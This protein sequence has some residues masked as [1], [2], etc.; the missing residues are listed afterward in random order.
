[1]EYVPGKTVDQLIG[2]HGPM[3]VS[4]A[5]NIVLQ[6]VRAIRYYKEFDI[7]HRDIKPSNII[8]TKQNIAKLGDFG[9]VKSKLD[10]E[11]GYEGMVLGTPDYISPEQAMGDDNLDWR[12]DIYSLG[13]TFYHMVTG[14]PP[15]EGSGSTVMVK[16]VKEQPASPKKYNPRL[17]DDVCAI[18]EKMMS[19]RPVDR[20]AS[21]ELLFEDLEILR[22]GRSTR[23]PRLEVGKS[24]IF[25]AFKIEQARLA[26]ITEEKRTLEDDAKKLQLQLDIQTKF[27]FILG[28]ISCLLLVLFIFSIL[29]II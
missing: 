10:K 1:M 2:E 5:V 20:Y 11:L 17:P 27:I 13:A 21:L 22:A 12:S 15:F 16:H 19:K 24:S 29:G 25:R 23:A 4:E 3:K 9:F 26:S 28:I 18:I 7:V 8:V 6:I 14:M